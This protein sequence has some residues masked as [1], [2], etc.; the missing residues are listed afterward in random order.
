MLPPMSQFYPFPPSLG[1]VEDAAVPRG[2]AAAAGTRQGLEPPE[3]LSPPHC[4]SGMAGP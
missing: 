4:F 3:A 2:T 1:G